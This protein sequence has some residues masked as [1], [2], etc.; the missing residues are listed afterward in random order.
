VAV[1]NADGPGETATHGLGR[2]CASP[3][4]TSVLTSA[5]QVRC[6]VN[7]VWESFVGSGFEQP[8][9]ATVGWFSPPRYAA[10]NGS[11]LRPGSRFHVVSI[12]DSPD[13]SADT[14]QSITGALAGLSPAQTRQAIFSA[15]AFADGES[16][17]GT[18]ADPRLDGVIAATGGERGAICT[19]GER[20]TFFEAVLDR[21]ALP[22]DQI[23]VTGLG[24]GAVVVACVDNGGTCSVAPGAVSRQGAG[25]V[26]DLTGQG[27]SLA[28]SAVRVMT[29]AACTLP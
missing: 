25:N 10:N 5:A 27:P 3:A 28:N 20:A 7:S 22:V 21:V 23:T 24:A 17:P 11:M 19:A 6:V 14:I 18:S 2:V 1:I 26:I 16:C 15:L 4:S 8:L 9:A 13:Q 29:S 12:G